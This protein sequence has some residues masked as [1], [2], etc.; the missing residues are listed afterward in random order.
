MR[1]GRF[2]A[3]VRVGFETHTEYDTLTG[4][5][6]W[7]H[8][9]AE[10]ARAREQAAREDAQIEAQKV[11]TVAEKARP[12]LDD[13]TRIVEQHVAVFQ[14]EFKDDPSKKTDFSVSPSGGFKLYKPTYPAASVECTLVHGTNEILLEYAHTPSSSASPRRSEWRIRLVADVAGNIELHDPSRHLSSLEDATQSILE[15]VLFP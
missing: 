9:R 13:L 11:K 8:R 5:S 7:I 12:T 3:S 6:D 1:L 2:T 4:M 10:E 15:P 14:E